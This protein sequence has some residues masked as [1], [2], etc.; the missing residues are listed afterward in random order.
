MRTARLQNLVLLAASYA[1]Y[2]W[3]DA[4]MLW[5]LIAA[6]AFTY[7]AGWTI[8][9]LLYRRREKLASIVTTIGVTM[10]VGL[11]LTFKYLDFFA[12]ETVKLLS[13][14]GLQA[15]WTT[16]HLV[17]PI[18]LSFYVFKLIS[19]L[20]EIHREHI[21]VERDAVAFAAYVAFFPTIVAGPIDRPA[22]FLPQLHQPRP[23][24]WDNL[25]IGGKM[26]L[27][28]AL[29]KVCI[30]DAL[31]PMTDWA[32]ELV[33]SNGRLTWWAFMMYPMQMYA[34]FSGYSLMAIGV[35]KMLG[36]TIATNFR[37][38]FLA[39]N[40]AEYWRR[41]HMSLTSWITDYIFMP[42]NIRWRNLGK[43]G[44]AMAV[45]V[46][47][48][49]IGLWHGANWTYLLFGLYHAALFLPLIYSGTFGRNKKM[50]TSQWGLPSANDLGKMLL[51]Y[52]LVAV[53]F[54]LFRAP[55]V[56]TAF[57]FF[58]NMASPVLPTVPMVSGSRWAYL[59][60][61]AIVMIWEYVER[62][63]PSPLQLKA[64][65]IFQYRWV[66]YALYYAVIFL[67]YTH[68]E[69]TGAFIYAQF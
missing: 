47:M 27:W 30:A 4:R 28:G 18:G 12:A 55:D 48:A 20:V 60:L 61:I 25:I 52:M 40:V 9:H 16:L 6:T 59:L 50:K 65:G 64:H 29:M 66:R 39:R 21:H 45:A 43:M 26:L 37:Q 68:S 69:H 3:L 22:Q 41:W 19:Y 15:T 57:A 46:N 44:Q 13:T 33:N 35:G 56:G 31:A 11:L 49:L 24:A 36:F 54:V 58:G 7:L 42:L 1:V 62:N 67:I 2:Y 51:T 23:L 53:A 34:D 38:P 5:L 14:L 8:D 10:L 32:W 63:Q 17:L